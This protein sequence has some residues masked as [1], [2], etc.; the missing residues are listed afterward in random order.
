MKKDQ[1]F[2]RLEIPANYPAKYICVS[3]FKSNFQ[4]EMKKFA[5]REIPKNKMVAKLV[6]VYKYQHGCKLLL[7]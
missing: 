5:I 1:V 3:N 4:D 7:F 6:E 2:F